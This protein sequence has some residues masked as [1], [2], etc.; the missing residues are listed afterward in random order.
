[1]AT[2]DTLTSLCLDHL[3]QEE[4]LLKAAL[5]VAAGIRDAFSKHNL[6]AFAAA[7]GGHRQLTRMIDDLQGKRRKFTESAAR[8]LGAPSTEVKLSALQARLPDGP[9]KIA[10]ADAAG[11]VRRL[12]QELAAVNFVVSVHVRVHLDAYRGILRDLTNTK[13]GSGRYGPAGRAETPDYR[14]MLQI[15]G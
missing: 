13:T 11:R 12:A 9:G 10:V 6:D 8:Q 3:R 15:N 4:A 2:H 7:L 14:P 1:M 5:P